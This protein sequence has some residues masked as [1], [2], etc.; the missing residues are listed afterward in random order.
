MCNG[1][2]VLVRIR[3]HCHVQDVSRVL[4]SAGRPPGVH[5]RL[6]V[7]CEQ[8]R[9]RGQTSR[10]YFRFRAARF[11]F[12]TCAQL[13]FGSL[14]TTWRALSPQWKVAGWFRRRGESR[15]GCLQGWSKEKEDEPRRAGGKPIEHSLIF[16]RLVEPPRLPPP[17]RRL[18]FMP[19]S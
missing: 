16:H 3:M 7:T 18:S 6:R 4:P 12:V 11:L 15:S 1:H 9:N 8:A 10:T 14:R 17:R 5:R 2:D 13:V 19:L